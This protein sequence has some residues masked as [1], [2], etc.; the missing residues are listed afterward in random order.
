MFGQV[1][2]SN[3]CTLLLP[4][5]ET[6]LGH[7]DSLLVCAAGSKSGL[8]LARMMQQHHVLQL[9]SAPETAHH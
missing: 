8:L 6:E 9:P 4:W 7:A 3:C 5:Q 1:L 2:A